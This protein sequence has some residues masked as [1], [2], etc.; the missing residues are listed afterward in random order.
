M[1]SKVDQAMDSVVG[2]PE[3]VQTGYIRTSEKRA[4]YLHTLMQ[5]RDPQRC[6]PLGSW[7]IGTTEPQATDDPQCL[8]QH[9]V[10]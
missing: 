4:L 8:L 1:P 7:S 2:S 3:Q 5:F 10:K 9:P 6:V